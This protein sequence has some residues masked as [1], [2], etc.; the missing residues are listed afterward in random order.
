MIVASA[1]EKLITIIIPTY[2]ME[3]YLAKCLDTLVISDEN[4]GLLEVLVVNDGSKDASGRIA[5]WYEGKYPATFRVIDK[6][7]G[8]YGSCVNKGLQ[9]A[10]G[11]YVKVLDADATFAR[12]E[13]NG[14]VDFLKETDADL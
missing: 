11:K 14:Y 9:E 10:K 8:N 3:R 13:F 12:E 2:N 4:M 6:E 5:H 7:N 1:M